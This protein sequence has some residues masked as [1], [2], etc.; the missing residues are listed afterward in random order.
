[1]LILGLDVSLRLYLNW[2][3]KLGRPCPQ[4]ACACASWVLVLQ[5]YVTMLG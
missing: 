3:C 4:D 2:L 5:T 1:L